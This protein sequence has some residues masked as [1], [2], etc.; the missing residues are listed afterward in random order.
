VLGSGL[1]CGGLDVA[2]G[3]SNPAEQSVA[4]VYV[5]AQIGHE[6]IWLDGIDGGILDTSEHIGRKC[7]IRS[8]LICHDPMVRMSFQTLTRRVTRASPH[9]LRNG[10]A[11]RFI[12]ESGRDV[13]E[14]RALMGHSRPDAAQ[15]YTERVAAARFSAAASSRARPVHAEAPPASTSRSVDGQDRDHSCAA[16]PAVEAA[17]IEPAKR[18]L[19]IRAATPNAR[20]GFEDWR[21]FRRKPALIL[22]FRP[23]KDACAIVIAILRDDAVGR[24]SN[25]I[26]N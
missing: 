19:R 21:V 20:T 5:Q 6:L 26:D 10:V 12:R 24:N 1:A 23:S 3:N 13:V 17:G 25:S 16:K 22:G 11:N 14:L 8:Q 9:Q 4:V 7:A 15:Q 2:E 18:S